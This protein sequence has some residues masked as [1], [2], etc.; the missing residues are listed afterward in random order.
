ME[1]NYNIDNIKQIETDINELKY[2]TLDSYFLSSVDSFYNR[3]AEVG[4]YLCKVAQYA[5]IAFP[6]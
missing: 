5:H 6:K 2:F 1:K 4:E 3:F